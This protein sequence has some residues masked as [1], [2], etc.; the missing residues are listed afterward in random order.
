MAAASAVRLTARSRIAHTRWGP[1]ASA[2]AAGERDEVA[3]RLGRAERPRR[4]WA[5]LQAVAGRQVMLQLRLA[6]P[7][8]PFEHPD[9]LVDE[10]VAVGRVADLGALGQPH[11]DE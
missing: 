11:V 7:E 6:N 3:A 4:G 8:A 2:L 5:E 1:A 9:L 10:R